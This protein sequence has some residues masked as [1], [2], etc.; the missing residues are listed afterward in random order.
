[1]PWLS[2]DFVSCSGRDPHPSAHRGIGL[3]DV[4]RRRIDAEFLAFPDLYLL[5][6]QLVDHVLAFRHLVGAE[7]DQFGALLD[8]EIGDGFAIDHDNDLLR[9]PATRC[10]DQDD[11]QAAAQDER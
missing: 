10:H 4:G 11:G 2:S 5:V 7:H 1:M 6:D 9:V 8:V 3:I